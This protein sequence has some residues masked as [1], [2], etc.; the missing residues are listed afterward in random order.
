MSHPLSKNLGISHRLS[1]LLAVSTTNAG[2]QDFKSNPGH[3]S[4]F[5]VCV[6]LKNVGISDLFLRLD[7]KQGFGKI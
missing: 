6:F 4:E 5:S 3:C 7:I 1:A 2:N